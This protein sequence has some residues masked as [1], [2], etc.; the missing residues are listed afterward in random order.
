MKKLRGQETIKRAGE[1]A[2]LLKPYKKHVIIAFIS[3]LCANLLGLIFPWAVKLIVDDVLVKRDMAMLN[4][5]AISLVF[6]FIAKFLFS[7]L[8]EYLISFVGEHVVCDLRNAIYRHLHR[9]SVRYV[10]NTSPGKII[11]GI[12]GDVDSIRQFLFGGALDF[13]Y[14]FFDILFVLV[15]LFVLDARLAAICAA[16]LPV[17]CLAFI[18]LSPRLKSAHE[19]LREKFA[20][21]TARINEVF[22]AIRVVSGY[23][24][25][26][27]ESKAFAGLQQ[28]IRRVSMKT[29]TLGIILWMT[30]EFFSSLGLLTLFWFGARAVY[31][32]RI[33]IGTLMAFYSYL[34]MLFVPVIKM[35][36]IN[37]YY[38]EAMASLD[39][40]N[41]LLAEKP[42]IAEAACP[43]AFGSAGRI[44]FDNV[45]FSYEGRKE[46]LSSI[47]LE[48]E[49]SRVV[50]LIGKSGAGKTTMIN[51]L[52]RF[53]DPSKGAIFIDGRDLRELDLKSYRSRIAMVLQDD[54]LFSASIMDNI[55]YGNPAA[56]RE[57]IIRAA[58]MAN[59][60]GFISALPQNYDTQIGERGVKLSYGQRQRISIAR[61]LLRD[62]AILILDEATSAV[63]SG[64]ERAIIDDAFRNLMAGRTTFVIAHRLASIAYADTIVMI[65]GGRIVEQ[66][67]HSRL[68]GMKGRYCSLWQEQTREIL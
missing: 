67:D 21:L 59:A 64:T 55:R 40:I 3:I 14:S 37:T 45:S 50:A 17:F 4:M 6:V 23:A 11:S 2:H 56:G 43:A 53:Y 46:V 49:A 30:A 39:R 29:H 12:I 31:S 5:L 1:I 34:A 42:K 51:L 33:S 65:E 41:G 35:V 19:V 10:E 27:H 68:L 28:D 54:Y 38:Q 52:L 7:F 61:A 20:V 63:D 26:E 13:I 48:V 16:Y 18:K 44:R 36:I 62:P 66:G 25:E 15:I 47:D 58:E 22:S 9:L 57:D 32:G 8:R 24:K 60:H